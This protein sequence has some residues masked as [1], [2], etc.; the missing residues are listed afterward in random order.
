[1]LGWRGGG[2]ETLKRQLLDYLETCNIWASLLY[3]YGGHAAVHPDPFLPARS[4]ICC[5]FASKLTVDEDG[6]V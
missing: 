4:V 2:Y 5:C 1:M 3:L 6:E